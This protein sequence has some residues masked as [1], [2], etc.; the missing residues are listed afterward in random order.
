MF[1][2]RN[3]NGLLSLFPTVALV[4]SILT[5][6]PVAEERDE[7]AILFCTGGGLSSMGMQSLRSETPIS[8]CL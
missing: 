7:S 4:T 1:S 8:W 3:L 5:S 6:E 2:R